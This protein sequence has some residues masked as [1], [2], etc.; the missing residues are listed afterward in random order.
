MERLELS[1]AWA[2]GSQGFLLHTYTSLFDAFPIFNMILCH[3]NSIKKS[4]I[5]SVESQ[6]SVAAAL[7]FFF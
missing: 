2:S 1:A 7:V 3:C 4:I 6:S 5:D